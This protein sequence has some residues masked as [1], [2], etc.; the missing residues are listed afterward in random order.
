MATISQKTRFTTRIERKNIRGRSSDAN[1]QQLAS[2]NNELER[3]THLMLMSVEKTKT[4]E[5]DLTE[6]ANQFC[7]GNKGRSFAF[8]RFTKDDFPKL[9]LV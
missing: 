8:V 2:N 6:I 9:S 3:L 4:D 7:Q 1:I 5:P